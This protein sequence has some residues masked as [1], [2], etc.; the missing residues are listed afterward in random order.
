MA[1][2]QE[3][4]QKIQDLK[5]SLDAVPDEF[6]A[7]IQ[8]EIEETQAQIDSMG[9]PPAP[10]T[11]AEHRPSK[12]AAWSRAVVPLR[13]VAVAPLARQPQSECLHTDDRRPSSDMPG[14]G[15]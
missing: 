5:D 2:K 12:S 10:A 9:E 15:Q 14:E 3:L 13:V 4:Q 6:K 11:P 8:K 1:T 7:D